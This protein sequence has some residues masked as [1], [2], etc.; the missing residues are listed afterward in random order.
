M[1]GL[2]P[3]SSPRNLPKRETQMEEN[4]PNKGIILMFFNFRVG[5]GLGFDF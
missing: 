2:R 1:E 4:C 3:S 5:F